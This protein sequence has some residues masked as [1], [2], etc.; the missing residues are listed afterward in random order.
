MMAAGLVV[1]SIGM[2]YLL[3]PA[4]A[5]VAAAYFILNLA[6]PRSS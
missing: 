4:F 5:A 3:S 2:G 1:L 6:F